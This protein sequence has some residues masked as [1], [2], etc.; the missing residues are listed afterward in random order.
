M[1]GPG[2]GERYLVA[3]RGALEGGLGDRA[4]GRERVVVD[5]PGGPYAFEGMTAAQAEA[6]AARWVGFVRAESEW[7]AVRTRMLAAAPGAFRKFDLRGFELTLEG[8]Y[9]PG[10]VDFAGYETAARLDLN[11]AGAGGRLWTSAE[12]PE[13]FAGIAENFFRAVVAYRLLERGA[14]L[15][16]SA[17]VLR[18]GAGFV[19]FGPSGAGKSTLSRTCVAAGDAIVSDDLNAV[20][21]D[22]S[23]YVVVPLPF[24]GE[25][26]GGPAAQPAPIAAL[27]RLLQAPVD[28]AER[29]GRGAAIAALSACTPYVN[30][31]PY[32][33]DALMRN[34]ERLVESCPLC[35]LSFTRNSV[36][37]PALT[38]AGVAT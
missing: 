14:V 33:A 24:W 7:A 22:G 16:H 19:F 26:R 25:I 21:P 23:S 3:A 11:R 29:V 30:L 38:A 12:D 6:V 35:M 10:H 36:P 28:R 27:C 13:T 34:L 32:R 2:W 1:T 5:L 17:A 31:D 15:L 8:A 4:W 20:V 18:G 9:G 37:W